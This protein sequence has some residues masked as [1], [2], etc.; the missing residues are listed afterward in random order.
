VHEAL[1]EGF[2]AGFPVVDIR[3]TVYDGSY[4]TVDSSE[5]S[6][7]IAASM[8][9]K[10][11]LETAH[12]V[13]LEPLMNVD[14]VTPGDFVGAVIGDLNSRR[15]RIVGVSAKGTTEI[16]RAIVPLAEMLKYTL[17]LNAV[18]GGRGS[19]TLEFSTYEEMP[20]D[21]ATRVIEE[22]KAAKQALVQ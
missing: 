9:F 3:V 2:L 5:M 13:L 17:A 1:R 16:I 14:V 21:Q 11:A 7:K 20:R 4:H 12:P 19:Y 8:A 22:Q 18:T 10:K 6:F 15:G